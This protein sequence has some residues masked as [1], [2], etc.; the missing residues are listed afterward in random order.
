M[1]EKYNFSLFI[2]RT[3]FSRICRTGTILS[4]RS[5]CLDDNAKGENEERGNTQRIRHIENGRFCKRR[6][7]ASVRGR[8][9]VRRH[10]TIIHFVNSAH[11]YNGFRVRIK[12]EQLYSFSVAW[13]ESK[14]LLTP[15]ARERFLLFSARLPH[16]ILRF[17]SICYNR[18]D[19]RNGPCPLTVY[20]VVTISRAE[21]K[22]PSNFHTALP[23]PGE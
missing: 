16:T 2:N 15:P 18:P 22:W 17:M 4:W 7:I 11:L 13:R 14:C 8:R 1:K 12:S 19:V 21:T 6:F 23:R 10:I 3:L 20:A 5:P 9:D